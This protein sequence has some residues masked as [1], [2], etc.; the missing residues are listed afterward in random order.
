[1]DVIYCKCIS[2]VFTHYTNI[3][4]FMIIDAAELLMHG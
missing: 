2:V 3:F 4:H 1:M